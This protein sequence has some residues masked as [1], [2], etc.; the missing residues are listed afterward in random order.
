MKFLKWLG[1]WLYNQLRTQNCEVC[2]GTLKPDEGSYM[3]FTDEQ[4]N[5]IMTQV[6]LMCKDCE[7]K[8]KVIKLV[9]AIERGERDEVQ[10]DQNCT[11][12][13]NSKGGKR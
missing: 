13:S 2:G 10:S 4:G 3:V 9:K 7:T 6:F 11:R 1:E 12:V 8:C 5:P